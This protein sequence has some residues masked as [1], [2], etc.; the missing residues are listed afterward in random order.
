M[1]LEHD[2]GHREDGLETLYGPADDTPHRLEVGGQLEEPE[3]L[4]RVG[5][6]GRGRGRG[7]VR[8]RGRGRGRCRG[9]VGVG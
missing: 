5:V 2:D 9:R 6:R 1:G 3:D 8:G 4:V 7:R